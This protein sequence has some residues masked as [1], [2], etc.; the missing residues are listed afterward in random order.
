MTPQEKLVIGLDLGTTN[1]KAAA[2]DLEGKAL[3]Q[4]AVPYSTQFP[5]SGWAEQR[6]SDWIDAL[7]AAWLQVMAE[8]GKFTKDVVG[9][10]L[11]AHGPGLVLADESGQPVLDNSPTWQDERCKAQGKWLLERVGPEWIGLGMPLTGFPAKL[12][13]ALQE[14]PEIIAKT[15]YALGIKEFLVG[16]LTGHF[17]TEPSSGPGGVQWYRPVFE[18]LHWPLEKLAE[19]TLPTSVGGYI[20]PDIAARFNVKAGLPVVMGLNDGACATL[21]AGAVR[22]GDAIITMATNGVARIILDGP[23]SP[24]VRLEK[25]LFCW[26]YVEKCWVAGGQTKSGASSLQWLVQIIQ[27]DHGDETIRRIISEAGESP[28]GS[29]GVLFIPY[30]MGRGSPVDDPHATGAFL[31]LCLSNNRADMV[32]AVLEGVSF[33]IA[34]IFQTFSELGLKVN[35]LKVTGGGAR[36]DLWRQILADVLGTPLTYVGT[37][38]AL[39]AA[40]VA[41]VGL[42]LHSDVPSAASA[43]SHPLGE[44]RPV[45]QNHEKYAGLLKKF[46]Q[47]RDGMAARQGN[48]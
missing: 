1:A 43:M 21:A 45:L 37:D 14:Q 2:Y 25:A 12:L 20:T 9:I 46:W 44:T 47:I 7:S 5:R 30:L 31:G 18:A 33:A 24:Q 17:V 32:R 15:R 6:P 27:A 28:V 42:G 4:A 38:S 41:A 48:G 11:S 13:W 26:P 39:G 19:V 22:T 40:M 3:A 36:S 23:I 8:L 34:E 35:R 16:W 10:G 29:R